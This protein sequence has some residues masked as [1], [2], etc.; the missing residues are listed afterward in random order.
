[1]KLLVDENELIGIADAIREKTGKSES[2]EFPTNFISEIKSISNSENSRTLLGEA[3]ISG[4]IIINILSIDYS[5]GVVTVDDASMLPDTRQAYTGGKIRLKRLN[6]TTK[7]NTLPPELIA[8]SLG[9]TKLSNTTLYFE[10]GSAGTITSYT[11]ESTHDLSKWVLEY[12]A[13]SAS[14]LEVSNL[15]LS[16]F[17]THMYIEFYAP[18]GALSDGTM[19]AISIIDNNNSGYLGYNHEDGIRSYYGGDSYSTFSYR[20]MPITNGSMPNNGIKGCAAP[21]FYTIDLQ[22]KDNLIIGRSDTIQSICANTNSFPTLSRDVNAFI[23]VDNG[24]SKIKVSAANSFSSLQD[25]S[26][27]KVWEIKD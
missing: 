26:Y 16:S 1:M 11:Q 2:M 4:G 13:N 17:P 15:G 21:A 23:L 7:L 27:L 5:T 12:H 20:T 25:G 22:K 9:F 19:Q 18:G 8:S 6:V 14:A 24:V 3:F 10:T